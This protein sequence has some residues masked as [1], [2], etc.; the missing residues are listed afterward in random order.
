MHNLDSIQIPLVHHQILWDANRYLVLE[1]KTKNLDVHF[2][3]G[4]WPGFLVC[5][6]K[7]RLSIRVGVL[8]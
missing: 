5:L 8:A 4:N 1:A 6:E 7:G 3:L 2:Q